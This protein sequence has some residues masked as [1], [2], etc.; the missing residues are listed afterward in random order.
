MLVGTVHVAESIEKLP[1]ELVIPNDQIRLLDSI[2]QGKVCFVV[3]A[4]TN[5]TLPYYSLLYNK[6]ATATKYGKVKAMNDQCF[7]QD[8]GHFL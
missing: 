5:A 7:I 2:G 6:H 3:L 1:Q 8:A 4:A